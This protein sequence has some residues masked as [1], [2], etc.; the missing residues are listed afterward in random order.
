[1][2]DLATILVRTREIAEDVCVPAADQVDAEPRWPAEGL[3]A[4]GAAGLGGLVVPEAYGGQNA[5]LTGLARVCEILAHACPSTAICF[6]MHSVGTAVIAARASQALG[7]K[8]LV[9]IAQGHHITAISLSEPGV[10]ADYFFPRC[11]LRHD[12][13]DWVLDGHKAMVT[14]GSHADSYVIAAKSGEHASPGTFSCVLVPAGHDGM[15]W[16][17]PWDGFGLRGNSARD[18]VLRG[19][20]VSQD[21][22]IGAEGDQLWLVFHAIAPHFLIALAATY[23]GAAQAAFDLA[24]N[25]VRHRERPHALHSLAQVPIV[26]QKLGV[27][28]AMLERTRLLVL[29]AAMEGDRTGVAGPAQF[30][31]KAEAADTAVAVCNEALT[32]CGGSAFRGQGKLG[33]LLRDVRAAPIMAPTTDMLRVW[34]GRALLGEP[35]LGD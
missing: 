14:N 21:H 13:D 15:Q 28:W 9:P 25:Y 19:V 34:T 1:M 26:Q 35:L 4:L 33:R 5:G 10:G 8:F 32:L 11:G 22:L 16:G 29:H 31:A 27:L 18:L 30:A 12:G 23:L 20:R 2:L 17:K 6:G 7:E 3:R 24:L